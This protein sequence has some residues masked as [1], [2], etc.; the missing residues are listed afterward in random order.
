MTPIFL[1]A[2][3]LAAFEIATGTPAAQQPVAIVFAHRNDRC[4]A[5]VG[6]E[7]YNLPQDEDRL[8]A[9]LQR[10]KLQNRSVLVVPTMDVPYRCV[11]PIVFAAQQMGL[12]IGFSFRF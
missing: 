8:Q 3:A 9:H 5:R 1:I 12:R 6:D 2:L 11:G 4:T 7:P 10:L